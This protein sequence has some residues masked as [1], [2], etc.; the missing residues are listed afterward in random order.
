LKIIEETENTIVLSD[1]ASKDNTGEKPFRIFIGNSS[2]DDAVGLYVKSWKDCWREVLIYCYNLGKE[3][4]NTLYSDSDIKFS[5][6]ALIGS[7]AKIAAYT[8]RLIEGQNIFYNA[9]MNTNFLIKAMNIVANKYQIADKI[10]IE[11]M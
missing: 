10:F 1:L 11:L 5:K 6:N 4:F 7:N 9:T 8:E 2:E 3:K